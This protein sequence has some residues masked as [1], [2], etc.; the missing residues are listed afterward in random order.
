LRRMGYIVYST[1]GQIRVRKATSGTAD[2]RPLCVKFQKNE[3]LAG[4]H[5]L[6]TRNHAVCDQFDT[7][8]HEWPALAK[9]YRL[10]AFSQQ[11]ST[12]NHQPSTLNPRPSTLDPRPSTL[13][14]RP[15]TINHQP[16]T[17]NHQPSTL[18]PQPS[19]LNHQ[20]STLNPQPSTLNP[21]PSTLN[22]Q[23]GEK[24]SEVARNAIKGCGITIFVCRNKDPLSSS[25]LAHDLGNLTSLA[26]Q[27]KDTNLNLPQILGRIFQRCCLW[28]TT[29]LALDQLSQRIANRGAKATS[30]RTGQ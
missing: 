13:N 25:T 2:V 28:T 29:L 12:L 30:W 4:D 6:L 10:A 24:Q 17:I 1:V 8:E 23:L 18:H 20:P 9:C 22:P 5:E 16:S 15:S 19:T 11:P 3:E 26:P 7:C 27:C 21:K 14:S